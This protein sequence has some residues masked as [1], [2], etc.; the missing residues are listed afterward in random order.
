MEFSLG[1]PRNTRT[2]LKRR[3]MLDTGCK[4]DTSSDEWYLGGIRLVGRSGVHCSDRPRTFCS[5]L[6]VGLHPR[7]K[8]FTGICGD[9]IFDL[10][11]I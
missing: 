6:F 2:A 7:R 11:S 4:Q 3:L 8:Y 1:G 5:S 10:I 9:F